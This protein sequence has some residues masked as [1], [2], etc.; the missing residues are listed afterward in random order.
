MHWL[1]AKTQI[2][3]GFTASTPLQLESPIAV[4]AEPKFETPTEPSSILQT[5]TELAV[6]KG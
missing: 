6:G 3:P 2:A 5:Q 4:F 1:A